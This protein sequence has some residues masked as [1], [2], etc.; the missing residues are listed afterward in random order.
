MENTLAPLPL[1]PNCLLIIAT[2]HF[3]V[4]SFKHAIQNMVTTRI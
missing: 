1:L 4:Y 2:K 3:L